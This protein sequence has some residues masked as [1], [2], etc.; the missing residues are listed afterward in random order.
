MVEAYA[1]CDDRKGSYGD[2]AIDTIVQE[3]ENLRDRVIVVFAGYP[4]PMDAFL[5]RNPGLA[6]RVAFRIGFEDYST[7]ELCDIARLM[8]SRKQYEITDEAM[9]K[10][11]VIFEERCREKDYGNGRFVRKILEE[12]EMN[13]ALRLGKKDSREITDK[14][15]TTILA[16]DIPDA[17]AKKLGMV[18]LGFAYRA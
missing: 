18:R 3:M 8:I 6:S 17:S 4:E 1:L 7:D 11:H 13:L 2:E 10:H 15:L 16:E 5:E 12:T 9:E 14:M